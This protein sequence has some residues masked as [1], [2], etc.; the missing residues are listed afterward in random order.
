MLRS[1]VSSDVVVK[2]DAA[3]SGLSSLL[4]LI[5][6]DKQ[7]RFYV[8]MEAALVILADSAK[9]SLYDNERAR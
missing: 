3:A 4:L 6:A 7:K 9:R 2:A 5:Y 8:K 1:V